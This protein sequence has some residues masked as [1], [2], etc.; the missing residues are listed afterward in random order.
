[1]KKIGTVTMVVTKTMEILHWIVAG[2]AAALAV[3][4]G[5][6]GDWLKGIL[7]SGVSE[8]GNSLKTSGIEFVVADANG[9]VN[10]TG[11]MLF[12]I[13]AVITLGLMAMVFR[14]IYLVVKKSR[15]ESPFCKDNVRMIREIG[16]FSIAVPVVGLIMSIIA[17]LVV[18]VDVLDTSVS[19][20]SFVMGIVILALTN[21]FAH[22]AKLEKDVDGLV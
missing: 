2:L 18:G 15:T 14:N 3:C 21:F 19:L 12:A 10:M 13:C 5:V 22:G 7:E 8:Y 20:D 4:C 11:V 6:A 9:N 17:K 16:I 1:M